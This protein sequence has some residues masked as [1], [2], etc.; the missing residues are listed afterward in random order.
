MKL[1]INKSR[2]L[3]WGIS[4][5]IILAGIISMVISWQQIGAPLRPSL[6]F[7]GGTRLQFERDCSNPDNCNQAIDINEV[8]E[9]ANAQGLG[10]SSIQIIADKDTGKDNG[11]LIRT[12]TLD[13]EQRTKLQNALSEKIGTFDPQKTQ[14]DTV[15]PTIGKELL[16]SGLIALVVSFIGIIVYLTFRFQL[17]F[18]VFAII[19]LFHDVLVT[20]G[21]FSILGLVAGIEVDSLF[22]VAL[23]TITGF[24]VNDTVVI[25]DRIRETLKINPNHPIAEIVDDAV[26]QT[27]T[28]SIN[29]TLTTLLTLFAIFLFGGATLKNFSLALIIGFTMGAYSSIFIASTLLALWRERKA[30]PVVSST[31]ESINS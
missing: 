7:V 14:I 29:T 9:V 27:L 30:Q 28:R 18:A 15:G 21:I 8:R 4:S 22:I 11:V 17:D 10:D 19:A 24:S 16:R 13:V 20:V 5:T 26:N 23:L 25:Y 2:S 1:S 6:D 31:S 3:W 12:K